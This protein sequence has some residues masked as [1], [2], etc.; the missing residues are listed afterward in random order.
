L[1]KKASARDSSIDL[2][3]EQYPDLLSAE[4]VQE[5]TYKPLK[6]PIWSQHKARLIE[7]YL[8]FFV[9]VTHHG[10]YIDG[11][12]GPQSP[13]HPDTWSAK[14]V[15]ESLPRQLR[16]FFF[17]ELDAEKVEALKR[18]WDSQSPRQT[19]EPKR[20]CRILP[21]DFNVTVDD[22]L[23]SGVVTEKEAAFALLDQRTFE[24]RWNTV[25]KLAE[26]K[27]SG[28]KIELFYF[29]A[30]KWL[31][32]SIAGTVSNTHKLDEWWGGDDWSSVMSLSQ[33]ETAIAVTARFRSELGYKFANPFPIY[34]K[35]ATGGS[36]MYYM[37]HATDHPAA[38]G[39]MRRA[40]DQAI[41]PDDKPK[42]SL[43][44]F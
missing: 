8:H 38:P 15:L 23:G 28:N 33:L 12:A 39:L 35:E 40:Y 36:I 19:K 13:D 5:Q 32:R 2:F 4:Q 43:L 25:K 26:H 34:E 22:V 11:F 14:R 44:P 42:Q 18:L 27:R 17:C 10:T 41:Q 24:C 37:I 3:A 21:G 1:R 29:L 30:V 31:H 9:L 7:R 6:H 16:H 20:D